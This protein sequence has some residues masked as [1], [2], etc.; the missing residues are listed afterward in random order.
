MRET[1]CRG[2]DKRER[3][4][5]L[6]G[7]ISRLIDGRLILDLDK[8]EIHTLVG[9]KNS[10]LGILGCSDSHEESVEKIKLKHSSKTFQTSFFDRI[11]L[12][13]IILPRIGEIIFGWDSASSV[14][15]F[16]IAVDLFNA[17]LEYLLSS[18]LLAR[19][20]PAGIA[21]R[22]QVLANIS[23]TTLHYRF[24]RGSKV[25]YRQYRHL[26]AATQGGWVA[27]LVELGALV[28]QEFS[29]AA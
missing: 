25:S 20:T 5:R 22:D 4:E 17:D 15:P 11:R 21:A 28:P 23:T 6:L 12:Q 7:D 10:L 8:H 29:S 24:G 19:L 3:K 2:M 26:L 16:S 18:E 1:I 27:H 9:I 14:V 13:K